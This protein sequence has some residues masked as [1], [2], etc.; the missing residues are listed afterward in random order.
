VAYSQVTA[1]IISGIIF[2]TLTVSLLWET[3]SILEPYGS[4]ASC[5]WLLLVST[6][7][8][9]LTRG[10]MSRIALPPCR[11]PVIGTGILGSLEDCTGIL[12]NT[13]IR[14]IL[15]Y[16]NIYS[17]FHLSYM[18]SEENSATNLLSFQQV[19]IIPVMREC[20]VKSSS[21]HHI[22]RYRRTNPTAEQA[23]SLLPLL[24]LSLVFT[25]NAYT[26]TSCVDVVYVP[27][28][29]IECLIFHAL[30]CHVCCIPCVLYV[31]DMSC[32]LSG[33]SCD[34]ICSPLLCEV[35][36]SWVL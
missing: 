15:T 3:Q 34:F 22:V 35:I 33:S 23:T 27:L 9:R 25:L 7:L 32:V 11:L 12:M 30:Y 16:V 18:S 1:S 10:G 24:R 20:H 21:T 28:S 2:F 5:W 4:R 13:G 19:L 6:P 29:L 36:D 26:S 31:C 8:G 14:V 17:S